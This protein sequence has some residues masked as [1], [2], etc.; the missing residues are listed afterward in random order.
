MHNYKKIDFLIIGTQKGGTSALDNYLRQHPEIGMAKKKELHFFDNESI[1]SK[2]DVDYS[3]YENEFDFSQDFKVYGES[4]PIYLYWEPCCKRI[5]EYNKDIKL[6][7][8]LRNP[9][10]RAFS[11]WNMEYDRNAESEPFL[12]CI[13]NESKRIREAL[14]NQHRVYSY[15][16]RGFYA[17][18]I[19]RYKKYFSDEQMLFIKYEEFKRKQEA[20]LRRVFQFLNV[21][22]DNYNFSPI[23]VHKINYHSQLNAEEKDYLKTV[24]QNDIHEVEKLLDWNCQD[25]LK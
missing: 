8:I 5:W 6:I 11:H 19:R 13:K 16:D 12:Y 1:F 3:I 2:K 22:P 9:I 15:T 21:N 17:D 20:E 10:E 14:P 7:V 23:T 24:F 25:W 18:Q 4:T